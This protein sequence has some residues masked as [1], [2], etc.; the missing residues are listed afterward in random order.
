MHHDQEKEKRDEIPGKQEKDESRM[1]KHSGN[2]KLSKQ[3]N[4]V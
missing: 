3:H 4:H 2:R 1:M